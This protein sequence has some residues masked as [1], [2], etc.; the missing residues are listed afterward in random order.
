MWETI[1][2]NTKQSEI[3]I[4][5]KKKIIMIMIMIIV[6][7]IIIIIIIKTLFNEDANYLTIAN[8]P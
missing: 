6:I 4:Y 3:I 1:Y 7:I 8:L 2:I 5:K